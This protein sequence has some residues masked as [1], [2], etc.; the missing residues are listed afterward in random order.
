M[1]PPRDRAA[2]LVLTP[3]SE[4][5]M[6]DALRHACPDAALLPRPAPYD[7]AALADLLCAADV[8]V[9]G[10]GDEHLLGAREAALP[11]RLRLVQQ[12]GAGTD[13]LDVAAWQRAGV[14]VANA[15]GTNTGSVAE[16]CVGATIALL[17]ST[18]WAD[19]QVR[20]GRWPQ[21][22]VVARGC[23]DLADC[24]VGVL[25][26]GPI[27][28]RAAALY[29]AFGC[30]VVISSRRDEAVPGATLVA[31]DAWDALLP[32]VDVL[33]PTVALTPATRSLVGADLLGRLRPGAVL[34]NAS[35]GAVVDEAALVAALR[36]GRLAGAAL[37]VF[38]PEPLAP[39]SPLRGLPGVL[40]SPHV[41]GGTSSARRRIFEA[42]AANVAAALAGRDPAHV[43]PPAGAHAAPGPAP[44]PDPLE[45]PR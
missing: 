42:V 17:R 9:G 12:P 35:R 26:A 27:G 32:G 2:V 37:D 31:P 38:D 3:A 39:G 23:R 13:T 40:L 41:A 45:E 30:T 36:S 25:G 21:H 22:E 11:H 5:G 8:V 33:V 19:A 16:W 20:D 34:V 7:A 28:R 4:S 18:V 14:P 6:V 1:P 24:T 44:S 29:R 10:W 43:L 15:P